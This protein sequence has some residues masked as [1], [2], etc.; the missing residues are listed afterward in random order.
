MT[1]LSSYRLLASRVL[2][3]LLPALT[4]PAD[5]YDIVSSDLVAPALEAGLTSFADEQGIDLRVRFPG[6]FAAVEALRTGEADVG[7]IAVPDGRGYPLDESR[8]VYVELAFEVAYVV[9]NERN[10]LTQATIPQLAGI[11]GQGTDL[12]LDRWDDLQSGSFLGARQIR[13]LALSPDDD[14]TLD[15]FKFTAMPGHSLKPS[16]ETLETDSSLLRE[17]A[18]ET[19]SIAILSQRPAGEGA[20]ALPIA[21]GAGNQRGGLAFDP[22]PQNVYY[23]DYAL[24]LP[25]HLVFERS[26]A[27]EMRPLVRLMMSDEISQILEKHGFVTIPGNLRK[28]AVLDFDD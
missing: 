7:I 16:V 15:L 28:S 27:E 12:S 24:R 18:R 19:G 22:T 17:I 10:P 9:I 2:A 13:A 21:R 14:L 11:Y 20:K 23:G 6:S 8:Y 5:S 4:A 25:V 1:L 3:C 26:R